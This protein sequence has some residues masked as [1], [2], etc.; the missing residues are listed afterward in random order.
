[1]EFKEKEKLVNWYL[2]KHYIVKKS[3]I[4][5]DY[6]DL[7][8][9]GWKIVSDLSDI[10]SF[11]EGICETIF[12]S[13]CYCN[14]LT[15]EELYAAFGVRK[16]KAKW[17][18]ELAQDL[19]YCHSIDAEAE[20]VSILSEE[21]GKEIDTKILEDLKPK[22]KNGDDF[23]NV[24]K[25]IGYTLGPT[26]YNLEDFTPYKSFISLTLNQ[27]EIERQNNPLWQDW[28]RTRGQD[29]ET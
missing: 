8:E 22:I 15:E 24:M 5:D 18:P 6:S 4:F 28:I 19:S 27:R 14:G 16:L 29:E 23:I 26:I 12:R 17:S 3:F 7:K 2:D 11:E 10:F 9:W 25:C 13:W 21:L 20:L 1:M